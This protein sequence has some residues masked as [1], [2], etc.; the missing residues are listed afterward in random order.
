MNGAL[1]RPCPDPSA[2]AEELLDA[3]AAH[4]PNLELIGSTPIFSFAWDGEGAGKTRGFGL[5][6]YR[7]LEGLALVVREGSAVAAR[8][9]AAGETLARVEDSFPLLESVAANAKAQRSRHTPSSVRLERRLWSRNNTHPFQ[10]AFQRIA[11]MGDCE[12]VV[13]IE[14]N[15]AAPPAANEQQPEIPAAAA[16]AADASHHEPSSGDLSPVQLETRALYTNEWRDFTLRDAIHHDDLAFVRS[17]CK[18]LGVEGFMQIKMFTCVVPFL[19]VMLD[20]PLTC[21]RYGFPP[22]FECIR[23]GKR[24]CFY[25]LLGMRMK[26]EGYA[27]NYRPLV[28]VVTDKTRATPLHQAAYHGKF[29]M[30]SDLLKHGANPFAAT[31]GNWLPI[32]NVCKA[33]DMVRST[34]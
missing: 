4:K 20:S 7:A 15:D 23:S 27:S 5:H 22:I 8:L 33:Y 11:G 31:I 24:E 16:P 10:L 2:R 32:H 13:L 12:D 26:S 34:L 19:P 29:D 9:V 28:H 14:C 25:L 18:Q 17:W 6:D 21:S 30:V 3:A 1:K